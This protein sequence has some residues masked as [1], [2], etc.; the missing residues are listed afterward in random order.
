M[1]KLV[2]DFTVTAECHLYCENQ[3]LRNIIQSSIYIGSISGLIIMGIIS[4]KYGRKF[5]YR[6]AGFIQIFGT[7]CKISD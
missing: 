6:I 2:N 3:I 5:A 4:D 7:L 1:A